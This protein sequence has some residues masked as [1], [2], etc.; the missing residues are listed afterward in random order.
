[1]HKE[2]RW[3][4]GSVKH[5][6]LT[7]MP[8]GRSKH[9]PFLQLRLLR[10]SSAIPSSLLPSLL[11]LSTLHF[12]KASSVGMIW[13]PHAKMRHENGKAGLIFIP[14]WYFTGDRKWRISGQPFW[15]HLEEDQF[16]LESW[17]LWMLGSRTMLWLYPS[18]SSY[19]S[20]GQV[21]GEFPNSSM[22]WRDWLMGLGWG[23]G[24]EAKL[25]LRAEG[26]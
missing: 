22:A 2:L 20:Q 19:G 13:G 10:K 3:V 11:A 15:S 4:P 12:L 8:K 24:K 7:I 1:M 9:S 17:V 18:F 6:L 26:K 21:R 16:A 14:S 5:M 23:W 25:R